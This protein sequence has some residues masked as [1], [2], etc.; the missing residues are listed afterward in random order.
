MSTISSEHL[1]LPKSFVP[2]KTHHTLGL[3]LSGISPFWMR[4]SKL[5]AFF[6][7]MHTWCE[8]E[9]KE[10]IYINTLLSHE[11]KGYWYVSEIYKTSF[12]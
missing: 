2:I 8:E 1:C 5:G 4:Q 9:R 10:N 11:K 12:F 7:S 3:R 6:F